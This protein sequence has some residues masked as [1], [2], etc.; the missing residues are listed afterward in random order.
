METQTL[1]PKTDKIEIMEN[2]VKPQARYILLN[3]H[4]INLY[5]RVDA[6]RNIYPDQL[7]IR[8]KEEDGKIV[9]TKISYPN[10][11]EIQNDLAR[12]TDARLTICLISLN[13]L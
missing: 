4:M 12:L 2:E 8:V 3:T 9:T 5:N 7:A 6:E 10:E 1:E 13:K 11:Q